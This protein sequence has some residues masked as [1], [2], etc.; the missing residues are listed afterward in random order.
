MNNSSLEI[1][2]GKATYSLIVHGDPEII[3]RLTRV[4]NP[5]I[6]QIIRDGQRVQANPNPKRPCGC[7]DK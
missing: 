6:A 1:G 7:P 5:Q 4:I 2:E 3:E